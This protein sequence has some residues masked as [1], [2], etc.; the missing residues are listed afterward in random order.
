MCSLVTFTHRFRWFICPCSCSSCSC[1]GATS[2]LFSPPGDPRCKGTVEE[3][4]D[5]LHS[6]MS[7]ITA[8]RVTQRTEGCTELW[9]ESARGWWLMVLEILRDSM[10]FYNFV[11]LVYFKAPCKT[12]SSMMEYNWIILFR[13][14]FDPWPTP[15]LEKKRQC[16]MLINLSKR[17][18]TIGAGHVDKLQPQHSVGQHMQVWWDWGPLSPYVF[19]LFHIR[20]SSSPLPQLYHRGFTS[21]KGNNPTVAIG[22]Y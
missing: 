2:L 9:L 15:R 10:R 16:T 14:C 1:S 17:N 4:G 11:Y 19:V 3:P 13:T 7:T 18:E 22:S 8:T 20:N 12:P 6:N 21:W 5:G